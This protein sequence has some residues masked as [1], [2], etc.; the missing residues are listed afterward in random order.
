[1]FAEK[2]SANQDSVKEDKEIQHAD[3]EKYFTTQTQTEFVNMAGHE[4]KTSIQAILTYS[5][6][7]QNKRDKSSDDYIKAILRNAQRLKILSDNLTDLAK[8]DSCTM[9]IQKKR[10]DICTLVATLIKDFEN[11]TRHNESKIKI[12]TQL[13]E[14]VF[15]NADPQKLTQVILNLLDNAVKFTTDGKISIKLEQDKNFIQVTITDTGSGIDNKIKPDLFNK[16]ATSSYSGTGLGLY[17]C[18]NIIEAHGGK[19][20][21]KNNEGQKGATF[22]FVIPASHVHP[23][24]NH[25]KFLNS[26]IKV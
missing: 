21:A 22:G 10:F 9:K 8:I 19:I 26:S 25:T 11:M 4:M 24:P 14:H 23:D 18:K 12:I 17:I 13:P 3:L 6:L 20:W 5:E 15:V 2:F 16:F 1:M 7:L